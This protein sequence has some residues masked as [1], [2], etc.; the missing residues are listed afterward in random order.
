MPSIIA[1]HLTCTCTAS[2]FA[3][4]LLFQDSKIL[5]EQ[6]KTALE[7]PKDIQFEEYGKAQTL[8]RQP[9]SG[10][11]ESKKK[12]GFGNLLRK[13]KKVHEQYGTVSIL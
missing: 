4:F 3:F 7:P 8:N 11:K 1:S 5:S 9:Q 2:L 6:N 12:K 10:V 13:G